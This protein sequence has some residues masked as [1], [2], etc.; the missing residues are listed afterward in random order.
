L[1]FVIIDTCI[2]FSQIYFLIIEYQH[3]M[4]FLLTI[5]LL[6]I[7]LSYFEHNWWKHL[8]MLAW[9][10]LK[11]SQFWNT[12]FWTIF[13]DPECAFTLAYITIKSTNHFWTLMSTKQ[14][15]RNFWGVQEPAFITFHGLFFWP[16][17]LWGAITFSIPFHFYDF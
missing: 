4:L 7:E 6:V 12:I 17:L 15:T 9:S 8:L 3:K 2:N 14:H 16:S 1:Q 13:F 5:A 10:K 11:I